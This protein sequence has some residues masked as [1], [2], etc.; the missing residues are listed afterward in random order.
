MYMHT[1]NSTEFYSV[2]LAVSPSDMSI[3]LAARSLWMKPLQERYFIPATMSLVNFSKRVFTPAVSP[4][5]TAFDSLYYNS[6][7]VTNL[8]YKEVRIHT[9][10]CCGTTL[11]CVHCA[12]NNWTYLQTMFLTNERRSRFPKSSNSII[13]WTSERDNESDI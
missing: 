9:L 3:F 6:N 4:C 5:L 2:T 13:F 12:C 8:L 1:V 11:L 10:R 7:G